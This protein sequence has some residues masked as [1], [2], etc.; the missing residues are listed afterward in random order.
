[1]TGEATIRKKLGPATASVAA[2][3][4]KAP[5]IRLSH[6]GLRYQT[7]AGPVDAVRDLSLDVASGNFVSILGPSGCGKSTLLQVVAGLLKPSQG[8]VELLGRQV[9]SP[10][11]VG[12]VFQQ[13]TLLPWQTVLDNILV[14]ARARG[15]DMN[16]AR[17]RAKDLIELV[18]LNG[19]ADRYP[20][21]LSGGMQQRVG[22]ARALL[23]E[24]QVLLMDEPFAAL[25]ALTRERMSM[26]LLDFW[27]AMKRTVLFVTHSVQE[28]TFLSDRVIVL[29]PRPATITVDI[30]IAL[31]RPRTLKTMAS[32]EFGSQ[33]DILRQALF[34]A[35]Q[36]AG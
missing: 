34:Q 22:I 26:D 7:E 28:A 9:A 20:Y 2:S 24:P 30:D 25:D 3:G 19:F 14:P 6:V 11:D 4:S 17:Q 23:L 10:S 16:S 13:P 27:S 5:A 8:S 18:R 36:G 1:M 33:A 21:E 12:M 29:S 32:L 35:A 31:P 15:L